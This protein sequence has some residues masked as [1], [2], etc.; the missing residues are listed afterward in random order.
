VE[1]LHAV[2]STRREQVL[3][4][5][6]AMV[7]GTVAP[8]NITSIELIDH[9]PTFLGEL[10][11]A[12]R[13]DVSRAATSDLPK[14]A[15]AAEHGEQ[16]LRL[17]FSLD[18]VVREYG[19]LR[20]AILITGKEAGAN[21]TMREI[22]VL[23]D[24][25]VSGIAEAVAEYTRQRDA[26]M[27]RQHNEHF[28]FIAHE[29]RNP[30]SAALVAFEQLVRR[31]RIP[32]DDRAAG[33]LERGLKRLR[34]LIDHSLNLAR[35]ASGVEVRYD[36]ANLRSLLEEVAALVASEAAEKKIDI[37]IRVDRDEEV[38]I[39][40]RLVRSALINLVQN[41]VK[42][43]VAPCAVD[44]RGKVENGRATIEIEDACGGLP[45]GKVE[46]AF[47][48]FVRLD[49]REPG[50]GLGLAIA[51]QAVDAHGGNIRVQNLPEKGCVFVLELPVRGAE[52]SPVRI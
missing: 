52:V 2:L 45:P 43:S 50:F 33:S 47:A 41:A 38:H 34:D 19:A 51:K 31:G 46:E 23:F 42:Y 37:H 22:D 17:G 9:L 29:L 6:K 40:L 30:L 11:D 25:I 10:I 44:L 20:E 35:V 13:A 4:R 5:W 32:A 8:E 1:A 18:A 14:S 36:P 24:F 7:Q 15:T 28:A 26:E 39:D 3:D 49:R 48:P 16:R 21:I 12:L 27:S